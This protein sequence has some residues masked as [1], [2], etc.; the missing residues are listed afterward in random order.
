MYIV[1]AFLLSSNYCV[2]LYTYA[3]IKTYTI[4]SGSHF[5]LFPGEKENL[6][7]PSLNPLDKRV[8]MVLSFCIFLATPIVRK[9]KKIIF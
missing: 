5:E 6:T 9:P 4:A 3:I 1:G 2:L 7:E 8:V